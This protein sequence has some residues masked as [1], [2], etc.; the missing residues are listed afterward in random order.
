MPLPEYECQL[1][2]TVVSDPV[3][4]TPITG[5]GTPSYA[6]TYVSGHSAI[7]CDSPTAATTT[8]SSNVIRGHTKTAVW[9]CTV[10]RGVDTGSADVTVT[11]TYDWTP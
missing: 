8:F 9:R 7:L 10:T 4:A 2:A 6:W 3:T 11:I 1:V 5:S